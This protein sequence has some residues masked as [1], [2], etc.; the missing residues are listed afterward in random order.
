M[1]GSIVKLRVDILFVNVEISD[2]NK[3]SVTEISVTEIWNLSDRQVQI[4]IVSFYDII[5]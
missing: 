4:Y 3:I 2:K 5:L 1:T